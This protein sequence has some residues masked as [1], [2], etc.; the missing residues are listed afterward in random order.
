MVNGQ[1]LLLIQFFY[2]Y[3]LELNRITSQNKCAGPFHWI[4]SLQGVIAVP[5]ISKLK[6]N[7]KKDLPYVLERTIRGKIKILP[8]LHTYSHPATNPRLIL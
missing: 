4:W 7:K 2:F 1:T 8:I 6:V 5:L 3:F